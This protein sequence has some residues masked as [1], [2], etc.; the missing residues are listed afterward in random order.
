[1]GRA[2]RW[3]WLA[4]A[5][6]PG[7]VMAAPEQV[8][9]YREIKDWAV[10][11]DNTR[12]C[13]ALLAIDDELMT[14][15]HTIVRREAGPKG[16][17]ELTLRVGPTYVDQ[18][19]LDGQ[20]LSA[21]WQPIQRQYDYDLRLEGDE[22]LALLRQLRNGERLSALT[23]DGELVASLQGLSA[24]LL[25]IDAVQE[26]VGHADALVRVGDAPAASVPDAPPVA[27]LPRYIPAPALDDNH[28]QEMG[29]AV[30]RW[31][32]EQGVMEDSRYNNLELHPL[33]EAHALG[34][35]STGCSGEFC[36]NYLYRVSRTA[37]YQVSELNVEAPVPLLAPS[38]S[39][40]MAFD[41]LTGQ[42]YATDKS[43]LERGCGLVQ[44][45]RYDGMVMRPERVARMD[46]CG[47]VKPEYWP[48]LWRAEG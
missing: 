37:P 15:L 25:A 47:Y 26:R 24:A 40:F 20:P 16:K 3:N 22:A 39:G 43:L 33:D 2:T 19:L 27:H 30:L 6:L 28:R 45:W 35:L 32:T 41:A 34:I 31:A 44:H 13:T 36:A 38:L 14:G 12:A 17:L 7:L 11:C 46:R 42:L 23:E 4:L 9:L 1:M 18:L 29:D 8:P 48:V 10:G 21:G 5:L